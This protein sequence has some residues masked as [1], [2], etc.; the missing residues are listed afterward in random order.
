MRNRLV[1]DYGNVDYSIVF[2]T[3]KNDLPALRLVLQTLL[4]KL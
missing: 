2:T 1:H 4:D 3:A